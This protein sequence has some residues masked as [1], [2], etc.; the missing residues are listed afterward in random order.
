[1]VKNKIVFPYY[2][3]RISN[4]LICQGLNPSVPKEKGFE[5]AYRDFIKDTVEDELADACIR[6]L[7]LAGL[8]N[9]DLGETNEDELKCSEGFLTGRLRSQ[10]FRSYV[11]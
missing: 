2:E 9:V 8:R 7:D 11:I 4:S 6:L 3:N 5:I 10:Y 1:M